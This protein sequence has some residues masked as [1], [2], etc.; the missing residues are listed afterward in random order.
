MLEMLVDFLAG[1]VIGAG[2]PILLGRL[3]ALRPCIR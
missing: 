3:D 2:G 1:V